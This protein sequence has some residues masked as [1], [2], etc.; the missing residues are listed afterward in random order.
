MLTREH[1]KPVQV[2]VSW[3]LTSYVVHYT[4]LSCRR[5]TACEHMNVGHAS[6]IEAQGCMHTR[7]SR[8]DVYAYQ[9]GRCIPNCVA[10]VTRMHL[11][12]VSNCPSRT[13]TLLS[14]AC[15]DS[16]QCQTH[17][18]FKTLHCMVCTEQSPEAT[19]S[20]VVEYASL[21]GC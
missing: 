21:Q 9:Q 6:S 20:K 5:S 10:S 12:V 14:L 13:L 2:S 18:V 7:S 11:E 16:L 3:S 1:M 17:P 8:T 15:I 4:L 19:C